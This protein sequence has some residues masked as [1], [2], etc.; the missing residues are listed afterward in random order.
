VAAKILDIHNRTKP[1][2]ALSDYKDA[3]EAIANFASAIQ[4]YRSGDLTPAQIDKLQRELE[5]LSRDFPPQ[6]KAQW[7]KDE[8]RK[9]GGDIRKIRKKLEDLR[10]KRGRKTNPKKAAKKNPCIGLHFHGKDA[11]ELLEAAEKS[12]KRSQKSVNENPKKSNP[13]Y[14]TR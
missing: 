14:R 8:Q 3:Q 12:A 13:R 7:S 11:D 10:P 6:A 9:F 5:E 4:R 2:K 1:R